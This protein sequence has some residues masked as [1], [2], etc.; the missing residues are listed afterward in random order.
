[1]ALEGLHH[2]NH[3]VV[4][5]DPEVV[6]L[7][8]IMGEYHPRAL[9]DTGEDGQENAAFE[10]LG[11]V[12]DDEG[13]MKRAPSDMGEWKDLYQPAVHDLFDHMWC[14]QCAQGVEDRLR[15][16]RH[17]L[18]FASREIA[19]LLS[20]DGIERAKDHDLLVQPSLHHCFETR[21]E[22]E[23]RLTGSSPTPERDDPYLVVEK[24]IECDPLL[25]ASAVESKCVSIAAD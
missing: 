23:R 22:G 19:E 12:D 1:M 4:A 7:G 8:D 25:G 16:G 21:R 11:F 20:A 6:P 2:R 24:E 18:P 13:I 15:P 10:R 9:A 14:D 3:T 5:T 17:L